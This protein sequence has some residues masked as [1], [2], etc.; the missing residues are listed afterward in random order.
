[1]GLCQLPQELVLSLLDL[2]DVLSVAAMAVVSHHWNTCTSLLGDN[3]W[4]RL[5]LELLGFKPLVKCSKRELIRMSIARDNILKGQFSC[6]RICVP[7][8]MN[9]RPLCSSTVHNNMLFSRKDVRSAGL[10]DFGP[11]EAYETDFHNIHPDTQT[12]M[13]NLTSVLEQE[14]PEFGHID[15]FDLGG[16]KPPREHWVRQMDGNLVRL[17]HSQFLGNAL[18]VGDVAVFHLLHSFFD[19]SSPSSELSRWHRRPIRSV[20]IFWIRTRPFGHQLELRWTQLRNFFPR[21]V[22]QERV[23]LDGCFFG[24]HVG[25]G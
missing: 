20:S 17:P 11:P 13:T 16:P 10:E 23:G 9:E 18:L 2:L 5:A 24:L 12:S 25:W 3:F 21:Q 14:V 4:N 19:T 15:F 8:S 1:M 6:T 7:W 22:G